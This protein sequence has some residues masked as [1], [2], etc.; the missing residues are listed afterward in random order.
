LAASAANQ[1]VPNTSD[2]ASKLG[3]SSSD[4]IPGVGTSGPSASDTRSAGACAR[5]MNSRCTHY[6]W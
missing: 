5:W 3:T 4:G 1:P 6:D 2:A